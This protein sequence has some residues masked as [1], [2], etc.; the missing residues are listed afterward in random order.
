MAI[1]PTN[2]N[3]T[4]IVNLPN[5]QIAMGSDLLILQ[6]TNGTQTITFDNFNV[7]KTDVAGN[8]TVVG[9][10]SGNTATLNTL[11]V[12]ALTASSISTPNG[13]GTTLP[14]GFY[15]QFTIQNGLILSATSNVQNDPVYNQLYNSD[16]PALI[17]GYLQNYGVSTVIE[18]VGSI[19]IP[20][21]TTVYQVF[22]D[23]FF[24]TP[25]N[26]NIRVNLI[27]PAHFNLTSDFIPTSGTISI[28]PSTL[29]AIQ[30]LTGIAYLSNVIQTLTAVAYLSGFDPG[31]P[32][33]AINAL[34]S[35]TG[36]NALASVI[37]SLQSLTGPDALNLFTNG[38]TIT[39]TTSYTVIPIID[40]GSIITGTSSDGSNTALQFNINI[41]APQTL[42]VNVYWKLSISIPLT[43][44]T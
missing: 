1:T 34:Q 41:G 21:G 26:S 39:N 22:V 23:K 12:N 10:L 32:V 15:N 31:T 43:P 6:T 8:A 30:S 24:S 42:P 11:S 5:A 4:S 27:T 17:L 25:P 40:P 38:F 37:N 20:V 33:S 29:T 9:T 7:V 14:T 35:L 44:S 3:T 16:L 2:S 13:P 28:S 18:A 19:I 36:S